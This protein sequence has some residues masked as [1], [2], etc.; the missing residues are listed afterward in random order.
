MGGAFTPLASPPAGAM[1][2]DRL[3]GTASRAFSM[4]RTFGSENPNQVTQPGRRVMVGWIGPGQPVTKIDWNSQSLP[5]DLSLG[6]DRSLRQRFVPELQ[7]LRLEH[8]T[9]HAVD[10]GHQAEVL[11]SFGPRTGSSPDF[12][13]TVLGDGRGDGNHTRISLSPSTGLVMVDGT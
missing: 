3:S 13:V 6:P 8:Y 7:M 5:R 12:G 1:G 9:G 11:A 4:A 10:A 2:V